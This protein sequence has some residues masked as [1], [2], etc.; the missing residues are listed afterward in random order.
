M[1]IANTVCLLALVLSV[2]FAQEEAKKQQPVSNMQ[3]LAPLLRKPVIDGL[4][5]DE[6]WRECASDHVFVSQKTGMKALR[7]TFIYY[8]YDSDYLYLCHLSSVPKKPQALLAEDILE[9]SLESPSKATQFAI[10][11]DGGRGLPPGTKIASTFSGKQYVAPGFPTTAKWVVEMAI[12]WSAFGQV[13]APENTAWSMKVRRVWKNPDEVAQLEVPLLF[14]EETTMVASRIALYDVSARA[15]GLL[16]NR[17]KQSR[18]VS[19][20]VTISSQEVPLHQSSTVLVPP[21]Q[22]KD[23]TYYFMVGGVADRNFDFKVTEEPGNRLIY[24]R[25]VNWNIANGLQFTNP[26]PPILLKSGIS[27]SNHKAIAQ[28]SCASPE[29]M[30]D[31]ET[32]EL[33]IIDADDVIKQIMQADKRADGFYF[34]EWSYPELPLGKYVLQAEIIFR[35]GKREIL[36]DTFRLNNF[37]WQNNAIGLER[38]VPSPFKPL[39]SSGNDVEALLTGYHADGVFWNGVHAQ[40]EEILAAPVS[41]V[42]NGR[43]LGTEKVDWMERAADRVIRVS[44]HSTDGL[45]LDVC[46]EYEFDGACK[47]TLA[48]KP[49]SG[50]R[51]H[52][53]YIDIPLKQEFAKLFHHTGFGIRSNPSA[54]IPQGSG[55]VWSLEWLPLKY[56]SYIWFGETYKGMCYFSDMTPPMFDHRSDFPCYELLRESGSVTLRVHLA[57]P[58]LESEFK[59]FEWVCGFQ[60]TPVKPRPRGQRSY[61]GG[62]WTTRPPHTN[63]LYVMAWNKHSFSDIS[64]GHPL[65]PYANDSTWLDY[66]FSGKQDGESREQIMERIDAILK[67]HEMNDQKWKQLYGGYSHDNSSLTARMRQNAIFSRDKERCLYLNP[68]GGYRCWAESEMYDAEWMHSGFY[69]PDD[70]H[71]H[72]HPVPSY[73]DMMLYKARAF[74]Q[75]YP[76]CCGLYYDNLYP[77]RKTSPFWGSREL[78]PGTFSFTGDIFPMREML[79]RTLRLCEQENR[80]LSTDPAYA[81]LM[82]HMTDANIVPVMGLA[83]INLG[84]E[85]KF[86][87]QDFQDR[88]PEAFHL[89]QS[90]GTQS[91]TV[92][93]AIAHTNGSKEERMKQQRTLYAVGFAFDMLNFYDSGSREEDGSTLFNDLQ[94]LV[95]EFGYGSA[96]VEHFPGYEPDENPV[97]SSTKDVRITTLKRKDGQLMLLVGNLG[98]AA[99]VTLGFHGIRVSNLK[100]AETGI[101]LDNASFELPRHDCAI[102]VGK[103]M[104]DAE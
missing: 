77:T 32:V 103:W 2:A 100:N 3:T 19:I 5:S 30:A 94:K 41:L 102:L 69:Q 53:L 87:R 83:S 48:F 14:S 65:V 47:V 89:V 43:T 4:F 82:V 101:S 46:H 23:F 64:F 18:T 24:S 73:V 51:A 31:V 1:K 80:R 39:K 45:S 36:Q 71:Y 74:L 49:Q 90:L 25:N 56:P 72:R 85:M 63:M 12:P 68:R 8:G 6:E 38:S 78:E 26:D 97:A 15:T 95:R 42:F 66:L 11:P 28:I 50:T 98:D 20:D 37:E 21:G 54:W 91:G 44:R 58:G 92:P 62:M 76:G 33:K 17:S 81:W 75:K 99:T 57:P 60:P 40:G 27:P 22:A 93:M 84:W 55:S 35:G 52:A 86:G 67:S 104:T 59:P 9:V 96:E 16:V 61:G 13:K 79:K 29:K 10:G 7:D 88:F 70:N 34:K